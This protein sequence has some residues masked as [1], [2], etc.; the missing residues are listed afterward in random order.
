MRSDHLSDPRFAL[1][2]TVDEDRHRDAA[3]RHDHHRALLETRAG[4]PSLRAR[5]GAA[6]VGIGRRD[7]SLTDYPCRLPDG[8]IG[9]VA[10]VLDDAE[11]VL[12]CR[13]A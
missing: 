13:V 7:H 8:R 12:V 1:A 9:R 3:R 10:V 11:W 2:A 5:L 4:V 6:I